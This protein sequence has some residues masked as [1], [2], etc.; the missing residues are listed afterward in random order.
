MERNAAALRMAS[1]ASSLGGA[2]ARTPWRILKNEA[3]PARYLPYARHIDDNI[4]ALDGRD[5]MMMFKLD[6]LAFETAD[7]IHLNDW[8]EKLNG[9]LRNI[10]DDRLAIW[11]HIVRRPIT[12]YPEGEFRSAFAADLDAKYRARVTA[13]RMFV[14]ELYLTSS[15]DRRSDRLIVPACCFDAWHRRGKRDRSRRGR[16][17]ALRG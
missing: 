12:D 4:I 13:K 15:C 8:H 2:A 6:G 3:D 1:R 17:C 5:L 9:T 10:A 7:P 16:A 14:N 11:T